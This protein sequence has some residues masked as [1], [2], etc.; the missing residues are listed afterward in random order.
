MYAIRSYY[1]LESE[2]VDFFKDE[3]LNVVVP[4]VDAFAS[5][6]REA[7]RNNT[8]MT[9]SWDMDLFNQISNM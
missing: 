9:A 6:V 3:G 5:H 2:L 1:E 7:Y 4:D 8:D